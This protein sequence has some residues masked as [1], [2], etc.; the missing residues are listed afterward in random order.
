MEEVDERIKVILLAHAEII[1]TLVARLDLIEGE[2]NTY[3]EHCHP[4]T[5]YAYTGLP[6][7]GPKG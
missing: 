6:R 4:N 7:I 3:K 1:D 5:I 2:L